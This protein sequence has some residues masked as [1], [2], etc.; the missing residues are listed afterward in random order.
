M[1]SSGPR[2]SE[3]ALV[4]AAVNTGQAALGGGTRAGFRVPDGQLQ[5][6]GE[7]LGSAE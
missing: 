5:V 7:Q 4:N 2:R 3:N 6:P 1:L